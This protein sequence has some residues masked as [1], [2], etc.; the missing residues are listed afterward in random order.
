MEPIYR[1]V[2]PQHLG[3]QVHEFLIQPGRLPIPTAMRLQTSP[4]Q[5]MGRIDYMFSRGQGTLAERLL[6]K[7]GTLR[8]MDCRGGRMHVGNRRDLPEVTGLR[9]VHHVAQPMGVSFGTIAR[10]QIIEGFELLRCTG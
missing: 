5:N 3:R 2:A 7:G 6:N 4:G 8:V 9:I 1:L 10:I